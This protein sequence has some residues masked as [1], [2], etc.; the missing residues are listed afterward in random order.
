V[1]SNLPEDSLSINSFTS[2]AL[3]NGKENSYN[4]VFGK[5]NLQNEFID[6]GPTPS[7]AI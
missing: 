7:Q 5:T 3:H 6:P 1:A 2:L 4:M